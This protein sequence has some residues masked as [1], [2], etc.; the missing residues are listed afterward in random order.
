MKK[1]LDK[2]TE[3]DM[4]VHDINPEERLSVHTYLY[5]T[6]YVMKGARIVHVGTI[7]TIEAFALRLK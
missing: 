2:L 3:H 6:H 1:V 5:D 4:H 7:G